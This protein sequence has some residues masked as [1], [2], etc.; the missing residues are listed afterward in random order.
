VRFFKV[1]GEEFVWNCIDERSA[2]CF[3]KWDT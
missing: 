2:A 3:A 1:V